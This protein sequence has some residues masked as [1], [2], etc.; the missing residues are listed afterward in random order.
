MAH[1]NPKTEKRLRLKK[2]IRAKIFGTADMPRLSVFKS[3]KFI[4]AQLIDDANG[5]TLVSATDIKMKAGTKVERATLVGET[6][7]KDAQAKK[8]TG[9]VFDRNGFKYTGRVLS[10]AEGARKGGLKF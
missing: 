4:S 8:I 9:A 2:K 6:L 1:K 7:A 5:V 10:L 3:N